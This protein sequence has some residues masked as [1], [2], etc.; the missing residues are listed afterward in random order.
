MVKKHTRIEATPKPS[1]GQELGAAIMT[2]LV[3]RESRDLYPSVRRKGGKDVSLTK[4]FLDEITGTSRQD[5]MTGWKPHPFNFQAA[6]LFKM[7]NVHQSACIEAKVACIVGLG[8][9]R[10]PVME[11]IPGKPAVAR[12]PE[13][14]VAPEP[15]TPDMEAPKVDMLTGRPMLAPRSIVAEVLDPLCVVSFQDVLTD[16]VEDREIT[17]NGYIEVSRNKAGKITG[18]FHCPARDVHVVVEEDGMF[19]YEVCSSDGTSLNK[20]FAKFG[21]LKRL[22]RVF[23]QPTPQRGRGR[24]KD[25][26]APPP[27]DLSEL[28][29]LRRSTSFSRY[30]GYP[31]WLSAVLSIELAQC[32]HQYLYDFFLNRGVPEMLIVLR[33]A[34]AVPSEWEEFK[35]NLQN[36]IG[37]KKSH[38]TM[39]IQL[40]G[41]NSALDVHKLAMEGKT[42]GLFAE[43]ADV[44]AMEIVS[45]HGVPPL[46]AGIQI[47]GKLGAT[48]ELANALKAFQSLR[49]GPSQYAIES[50][51]QVTLGREFPEIPMEAWKLRTILEEINVDQVDTIGRMREPVGQAMA[52]GRD[53][54]E[55]VKD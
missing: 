21:D 38:K 52:G 28:I 17:G 9:R 23:P 46:L 29:H 34:K 44:L 27:P 37:L 55:G 31:D 24:P 6:A 25:G 3:N 50:T 5:S 39:A 4:A 48:N 18:L 32:S 43:L 41:E 8:F 10:E 54:A 26:E 12:D 40:S 47:P 45:A 1:P 11:T 16:A 53:L 35:T 49:V 7:F 51:L 36:H 14:G 15:A 2:A 30:Y 13:L 33:G 19:H 22:R 42:D 20:K